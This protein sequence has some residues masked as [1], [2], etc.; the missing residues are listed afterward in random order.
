[1]LF[2]YHL[3][4]TISLIL[5]ILRTLHHRFIGVK[6]PFLDASLHLLDYLIHY[7]IVFLLFSL[8]PH[9][10]PW[11]LRHLH[12]RTWQVK[13]CRLRSICIIPIARDLSGCYSRSLRDDCC[14]GGFR[15]DCSARLGGVSESGA[16]DSSRVEDVRV[17]HVVFVERLVLPLVDIDFHLF[18][19]STTLYIDLYLS[20]F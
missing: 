20:K 8:F 18:Y 16:R 2:Y 1:M 15:R 6:R 11:L 17:E 5:A 14:W 10:H 9:L 12:L 4:H 3:V 7:F 13:A 19:Q